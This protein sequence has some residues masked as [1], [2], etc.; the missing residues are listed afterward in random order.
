MFKA[1]PFLAIIVIVYNVIVLITGPALATALWS[2]TLPSGAAWALGLGDI[3]IL[4]GILLLFLEIL[5]ATHS[6][7]AGLDHA[8]SMILFVVALLEFLLVPACGT[9]VF[10]IVTALTLVDV[11]AGFAVSLSSARRDIAIN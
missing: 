5:K 9:D 1:I 6:R 11:I 3:I 2:A 7:R 10:L 8:L 4:G